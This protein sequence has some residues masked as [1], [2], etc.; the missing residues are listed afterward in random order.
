MLFK[1]IALFIQSLFFILSGLFSSPFAQDIAT[2]STS[3]NNSITTT[4][5]LRAVKVTN[6]TPITLDGN[7]DEEIWMQVP[8]ATD[9]IQRFPNDG[10]PATEKT[11][12][13][14]IYTED[15]IYVGAKAYDS[16]TDS[17]AATLFRRDGSAY[18]DWFYVNIDSY[19]D[20]RTGFSFAV[21]PKGVRKD[22]L[23]FD[24]DD[25]DIRWDAVWKAATSIN[26]EGWTVE[27]RIPLSQLRFSSTQSNTESSWGINFQRRIAR[28]EEISFWSPTPQNESGF[29]S[30][31]GEL[32]GIRELES[33]RRFEVRPYASTN[34]IREPGNRSNPF[35]EQNN[36]T[37]SVG[38]DL[39]YGI[40][41]DLTLTATINP[42]FGQV[43][44]DPAVINLTA[45]EIFF[46]EQ[47]P[48]FLEGNEIFQFGNTRTFSS[49]GNPITF[50]SRRIGRNPQGSL[51]SYN[52]YRGETIYDPDI[53]DD[54]DLYTNLPDQ[55]T[56]AGAAKLSGKTKSGWSVG[57]LNAYTVAESSPYQ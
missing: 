43:E 53:V 24:D 35:H 34:L 6:L 56:I 18:S 7:L 41:P 57:L 5:S 3:E 22:I 32:Q 10:N 44:A 42:D 33:P 37:G 21:N 31:F 9:F 30:R 38:A 23:I 17:I 19:D 55:T 54:D 1:K 15:A 12:A 40:T 47:R 20:N 11:E 48:F 2:Q 26:N 36:W 50:Y 16:S 25:E 52:D 27:M 14:V 46:Q 8:V 4:R 39:K 28:N 29:V 13:R 45:F 49:F 51:D